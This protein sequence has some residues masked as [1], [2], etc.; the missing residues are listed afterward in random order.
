MELE[1]RLG[2]W[3]KR[4]STLPSCGFL[5][6]TLAQTTVPSQ[7]TLVSARRNVNPGGV[8]VV[9]HINFSF[10]L[11]FSLFVNIPLS[12]ITCFPIYILKHQEMIHLRTHKLRRDESESLRGFSQSPGCAS[13]ARTGLTNLH[14]KFMWIDRVASRGRSGKGPVLRL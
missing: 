12:N 11:M 10:Q 9:K 5:I 2:K 8:E 14:A 6:S 3:W 13:T 1:K 4:S 7:T